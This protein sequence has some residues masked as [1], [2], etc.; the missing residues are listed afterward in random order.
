MT[1]SNTENNIQENDYD[2]VVIIENEEIEEGFYDFVTI[3]E[4]LLPEAVV[5]DVSQDNSDNSFIID[6]GM[7][8]SESFVSID[9]QI[10]TSDFTENDF[11]DNYLD[12]DILENTSL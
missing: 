11:F 1:N 5:I 6:V 12:L 3:D 10:L 2:F 9:E 4:D 7:T 8:N